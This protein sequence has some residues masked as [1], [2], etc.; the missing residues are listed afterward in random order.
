MMKRHAWVFRLRLG[1]M[2]GSATRAAYGP[3]AASDVMRT[4]ADL[5]DGAMPT[6][7]SVADG[8][9]PDQRDRPVAC[10]DLVVGVA[11]VR[12]QGQCPGPLTRR[13]VGDLGGRVPAGVFACEHVDPRVGREIAVP[14]RV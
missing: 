13:E 2:G 9:Q 14:G 8:L 12:V 4:G 1:D 7:T 10:P 3:D 11:R 6:R 5:E